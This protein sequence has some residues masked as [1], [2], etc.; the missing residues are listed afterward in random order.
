MLKNVTSVVEARQNEAKECSLHRVNEHIEPNFNA[1][2]ASAV[3]FQQPAK[4]KCEK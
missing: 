1:A 4:E 3:V 2:S